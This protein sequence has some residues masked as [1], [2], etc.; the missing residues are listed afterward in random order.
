MSDHL[1]S[2]RVN[3]AHMKDYLDGRHP[4]RITGKVLNFASDETYLLMEASDGGQIKVLLPQHPQSHN[5]TDTFVEIIG[6]IVNPSTIKFMACINM[7]S[8][9]DLTLVNQ[10]VELTFDP[11]FRG[12]LF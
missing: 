9:L 10:V 3:S 12:R 6:T 1:L 8:N 5:V 4:V 2:P 7:G 11:K